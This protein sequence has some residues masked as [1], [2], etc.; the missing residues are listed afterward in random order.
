MSLIAADRPGL[1]YN[2]ANVFSR[3]KV[4]LHTAKI[5]TLGDRV[6]DTFLLSGACLGQTAS[7]V[8]FEQD[9]LEAIQI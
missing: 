1:L 4:A 2:V 9:M 3:H 6:E 8:K 5:T 7:L